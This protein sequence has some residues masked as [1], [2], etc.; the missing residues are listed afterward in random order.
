[1][2]KAIV[3]GGS[4]S[5]CMV[6]EVLSRCFNEVVL[7]EKD[8]FENTTA[9]RKGVPQEDHLHIVLKHGMNII[10]EIFPELSRELAHQSKVDI[11]LGEGLRWYQARRWKIPFESTLSSTLFS[12]VLLDKT[13]RKRVLNNTAVKINCYTRVNGF[14]ITDNMVKGVK[15]NQHG[16]PHEMRCDLVVDCSGLGSKTLEWLNFHG[17]GEVKKSKIKK[18]IRYSSRIYRSEHAV[19]KNAVVIWDT[20]SNKHNV[21]LM[22][23]IEDNKWIISAGRCFD[24]APTTDETLYHEFLSA[25]PV[26]NISNFINKSVAIS[27][28]KSFRYSGST[29]V[30]YEKMS[31]FPNGLIV[32]GAAFCGLNPF[33][34]QG[35]TLCA[36]QARVISEN[37]KKYLDKKTDTLG[38]QKKMAKVTRAPWLVAEVEDFRHSRVKGKRTILTRFLMW[39]TEKFHIISNDNI[40]ARELQLKLIHQMV[41]P[42]AIFTPYIFIRVLLKSYA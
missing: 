23:P 35:I 27:P 36:S 40:F 42:Y 24:N 4:I 26:Q 11:N 3:I 28:I 31:N 15:F 29:W 12:R 14:I 32:T 6:A 18:H 13:I 21:G 25:L 10:D 22:F 7:F 2:R 38:I 37:I 19:P 9:P 34:G 41:S 17:M 30:H 33:F 5:G 20:G 8:Q 16:K 1:M 39:Y